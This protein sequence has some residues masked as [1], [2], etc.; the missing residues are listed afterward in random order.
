M[1]MM[2]NAALSCTY[3]H[4]VSGCR[5]ASC[6]SRPI[7]QVRHVLMFDFPKDAAT[8]IHRAG[9]TARSG[10]AGLVTALVT[11]YDRRLAERIRHGEAT[12]RTILQTASGRRGEKVAEKVAVTETAGEV[13]EQ[14]APREERRRD[15]AASR[16]GAGAPLETQDLQ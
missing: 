7:W 4:D 10:S 11:P 9:R 6:G 3:G 16:R 15:G 12:P 5:R 2:V 8:Y 1:V 13:A 14:K